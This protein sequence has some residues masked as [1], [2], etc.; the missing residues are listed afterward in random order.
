LRVL[1]NDFACHPANLLIAGFCWFL[2]ITWVLN[3]TISSLGISFTMVD[4]WSIAEMA[5]AGLQGLISQ[6]NPV[7]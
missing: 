6:I 5:G 4:S 7:A 2:A 3:S 1:N